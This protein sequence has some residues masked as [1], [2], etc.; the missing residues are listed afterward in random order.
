MSIEDFI[1]IIE[2]KKI[3]IF[4]NVN[5]QNSDFIE[6]LFSETIKCNYRIGSV[7]YYNY[8]SSLFK[9]KK[10]SSTTSI[11]YWTKRGYSE[12]ESIKMI[13]ELQKKKSRFSK[14]YWINKGYSE[15][16][17][18]KL[19]AKEQ[20]L[21]SSKGWSKENRKI[22]NAW[23]IQ[24]WIDKGYSL[25]ESR[26]QALSRNPSS[27]LFY[28]SEDDWLDKRKRISD[29]VSLFI[30][31]NPEVYKSF[32]GSKS[33]AE[34]EFFKHIEN[35][36]IKH[37]DFIICIEVNNKKSLYKADGYYK[38]ESSL[39]LIEFDGLYWHKDKKKDY[40]R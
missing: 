25:E 15:E 40:I 5:L 32:F 4:K 30:K 23:S 1:S 39:I 28:K 18:S 36:S 10:R 33:K 37:I 14:E 22:G 7:K 34:F 2:S 20:S 16:E 31:N 19:I 21:V 29:N 26:I 13:S 11:E 27:R 12:E 35:Q 6:Y 9:G 24:Y 38:D 17:C 8:I 3:G